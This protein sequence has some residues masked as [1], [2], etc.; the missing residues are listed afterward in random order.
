[1]PSKTDPGCIFCK[2]VAG[3]VPG[4]QVYRDDSAMV[5]KDI[6]P[7]AP[8]HLLVVPL[9]HVTFVNSTRPDEEALIGHLVRVAGSVARDAGIEK[10][11]YRI[12]INQGRDAGQ[13]VDHLHLHVL[14]GRP[15][16]RSA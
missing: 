9:D 11:G 7:L 2:I 6:R 8:T 14:G 16:G 5:F 10:S 1:M 4:S 3:Q 12:S 13:E 15:L